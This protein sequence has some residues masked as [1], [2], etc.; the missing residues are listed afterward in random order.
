M[1]HEKADGITTSSASK[2]FIYFL[3]RGNRKRGRFFVVKRTES[4]VICPSFF[5]LHKSAH[6]FRDVDAAENLLYG[7]W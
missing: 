5:Q 7:L 2:T 1:L 4:Q 6:Y 3:G